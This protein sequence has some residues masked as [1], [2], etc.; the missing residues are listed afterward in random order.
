MSVLGLS[1]LPGS[2]KSS[3]AVEKIILPALKR[4]ETV[5]TNIRGL[6]IEK[7][8]AV[9]DLDLHQLQKNFVEIQEKQLSEF[10]RYVPKNSIIIIDE[11][12][13][14]F[15]SSGV[16]ANLALEYFS[17]HRH[18]G[19]TVYLITQNFTNVSPKVST[20]VATLYHFRD[21]SQLGVKRSS[22]S[23][24]ESV[25]ILDSNFIRKSS[26]SQDKRIFRLY[27]SYISGVTAESDKKPYQNVFQNPKLLVVLFVLLFCGVFIGKRA[28]FPSESQIGK[29]SFFVRKKKT[30]SSVPTEKR[31]PLSVPAVGARAVD[32]TGFIIFE[33][34]R[35]E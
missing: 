16:P 1:G 21:L 35:I 8:S 2:G 12:Q 3:Y 19:H 31:D 27:E 17:T 18:L 20:M 13:N 32:S 5:C 24:Y 7:I 28:F 34:V 14:V 6:S 30:A 23:V 33:G 22:I 11:V 25:K 10:W 29:P 15:P 9:F 26:Y 4:G